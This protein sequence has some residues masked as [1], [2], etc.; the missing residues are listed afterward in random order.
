MDVYAVSR[1]NFTMLCLYQT[2]PCCV[3][4]KLYHAVSLPNFTMLCLYQTLPCCVS[5][6]LYHGKLCQ[7]AAFFFPTMASLDFIHKIISAIIIIIII[8]YIYIALFWVLKAL[9]IEGG[10]LL[11]YHQCAAS[12][13]M[14]RRQP[15]CART[16]TTHQLIGGEETEWWTQS[17]D[18]GMIRRPW[19]SEANRQIWPGC[20]GYTPTLFRRTSWDF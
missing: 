6:K 1:P 10:N 11:N 18:T 2:L 3:S 7:N 16:P 19:W 4:T 5:T 14:M 9:Y 12:T 13:W 8:R 17:A 20:R 15:Y